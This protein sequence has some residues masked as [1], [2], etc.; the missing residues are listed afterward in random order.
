MAP[1]QRI[2][3]GFW[4]LGAGRSQVQILSPRYEKAPQMRGF[5]LLARLGYGSAYPRERDRMVFGVGTTTEPGHRT[6]IVD[7]P[8]ARIVRTLPTA[9]PGTLLA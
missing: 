3:R 2:C 4:A 9:Q 6:W 5:L 7:L 8:N 1:K